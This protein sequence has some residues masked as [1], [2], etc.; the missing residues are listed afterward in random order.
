MPGRGA[1][2]VGLRRVDGGDDRLCRG[3]QAKAGGDDHRV[4]H[5]RERQGR[6]ARRRLHRPVQ[7]VPAHEAHHPGEHPRLPARH[8]VRGDR[9]ARDGRARRP[10]G[11]ADDRPAAARPPRPSGFAVHLL[12]RGEKD[13]RSGALGGARR[14]DAP[15]CANAGARDSALQRA[16]RHAARRQGAAPG[17][18][19]GLDPADG[20]FPV[21]PDRQLGRGGGGAVRPVRARVRPCAGDEPGR[22]GPGA[23]LH[24][25][26]PGRTGEGP[27][28]AKER[29]ARGVGVAGGAGVRPAGDDPLRGRGSGDE[30]AGMADGRLLHRHDQPVEP[31]ARPAAGRVQGAGAGADAGASAAGAGRPAGRRRSGRV[32]GAVDGAADPGRL[33]GA[34]GDRPSEARRVAGGLGT[35]ELAR[36][37]A[38]P[39][40]VSADGGG[41][42]GGGDRRPAAP[43]GRGVRGD[44]GAWGQPAGVQLPAGGGGLRTARGPG[45]GGGG[46]A[47]A[48]AA[49][50]GAGDD[51]SA[52]RGSG[53]LARRHDA[54]CGR[55]AGRGGAD[56]AA[57]PDQR[58]GEGPPDGGVPDGGAAGG[59]RRAEPTREPGRSL[60]PRLPRQPAEGRAHADARGVGARRRGRGGD[61][62]RPGRRDLND[63]GRFRDSNPAGPADRACGAHGAGR[64]PGTHGRCDGPG[65]HP[66]GCP[67]QRR[68]RGAPGRGD[69][70]R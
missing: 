34:G 46:P 33:P 58:P 16:S 26:L 68:L 48:A 37:G 28:R 29:V 6:R 47:R 15:A 60:S 8:E 27:A 40:A 69:G 17:L 42:R 59:R 49:G 30:V 57:G 24:H 62:R 18:G 25:P 5:G 38:K 55:G 32:V 22:H 39:G 45:G 2:G 19:G 31:A 12:P 51:G 50:G 41:L 21:V 13:E 61:A 63:E 54:P 70:G 43:D 23:H 44:G 11:A 66:R 67:L 52:A 20:G 35:A 56:G 65:L 14:V 9:G 53:D 64:G 10:G 7:P 3:A 4:L 1:G 36:G